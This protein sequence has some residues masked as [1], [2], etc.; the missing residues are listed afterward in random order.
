MKTML[1][2]S[3]LGLLAVAFATVPVDAN[4]VLHV[5]TDNNID[6]VNIDGANVCWTDGTGYYEQDECAGT[7]GVYYCSYQRGKDCHYY[8]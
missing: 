8:L 1:L 6:C 2:M 4:S 7:H 5:C 3:A